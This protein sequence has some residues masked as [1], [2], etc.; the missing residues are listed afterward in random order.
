VG[1]A[2]ALELLWTGDFVHADEA[3]RLGMVNYVYPDA[4][5][6]TRALELAQRIADGPPVHLRDIKKLTY[7]AQRTDL[8]TSLEAVSAHMAV[9]QSTED[10]KE[11]LKAF[12]EKRKPV[13]KGR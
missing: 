5:L 13:F 2:R 7:Q 9:V 10:Y 12:K 11:A 4:E 3:L 6:M 1:L 8:L